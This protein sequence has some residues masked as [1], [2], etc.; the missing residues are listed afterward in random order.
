MRHGP[1]LSGLAQRLGNARWCGALA[2]VLPLLLTLVACDND[3]SAESRRQE[4]MERRTRVMTHYKAGQD[5]HLAVVWDSRRPGFIEGATLAAEE[6]NA[7]TAAIDQR[8]RLEAESQQRPPPARSPRLVLDVTD[9]RPFIDTTAVARTRDEGRYRNAVSEA[10][11]NLARQVLS[12]PEVSAVIGHTHGSVTLAAMLS[13]QK[14]GVL[15]LGGSSTD[16]RLEWISAS[17]YSETFGLYFQ[18]LP[19]DEVLAQRIAEAFSARGWRNAYLAYDDHHTNE[20]L[21]QLLTSAFSRLNIKVYGSVAIRPHNGARY[22]NTRRFRENLSALGNSEVDAIVLLTSAKEGAVIIRN[23]RGLGIL[24]P[25]VGTSEF[26]SPDFVREVGRAGDN[27]LV[28][29]LYRQDTFVVKQFAQRFT[30]RFPGLE[31]NETAAMGYDSARLY[32]EAVTRAGTV[33]PAAVSHVMRYDLPIFYGLLG[34]YVLK[35]GRNGGSKYH[36]LRLSRNPTTGTPEY[37]SAD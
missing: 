28:T 6:F 14:H 29:T 4:R 26:R 20:N 30:K 31:P 33:D 23:G 22:L 24:Q 32:A 10:G 17:D 34:S 15:L 37:V 19:A 25:F 12:N 7:E 18:L 13:Y 1:P 5:F 9:E 3:G 8:L 36:L 16:A 27:T 2:L 21:A 11:T 35:D